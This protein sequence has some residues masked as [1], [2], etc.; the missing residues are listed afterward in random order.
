MKHKTNAI[1]FVILITIISLL[2]ACDKDDNPGKATFYTLSPDNWALI[3]DGK[4]YGKIRN[5]YQMPVCGD[6]LF[7]TISLSAGKHTVDA[8]SLDGYAWGSPKTITI[9]SDECIQVKLP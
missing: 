6:P 1:S 9:K 8:R 3:I 7:Q 4:E 5:T 2:S